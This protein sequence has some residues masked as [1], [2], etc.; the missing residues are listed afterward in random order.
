MRR[1]EVTLAAVVGLIVTPGLAL[2]LGACFQSA[3]PSVRTAE[4]AASQPPV[5]AAPADGSSRRAP[6]SEPPPS[7][8]PPRAEEPPLPGPSPR[9][10]PSAFTTEPLDGSSATRAA[11]ADATSDP[12]LLR[13]GLAT[14][15]EEAVIPCCGR[16]LVLTSGGRRWAVRSPLRVLPDAGST[17]RGAFRLQ[18]AALKDEG[19]ARDL[20]ARLAA[21]SGFASDFHF[22]AGVD[23][24]RVRL[25]R[26][27]SRSE[28]ETARGR[29]EVLG[30]TGAWIV[31]EGGEISDPAFLVVRAGQGADAPDAVRL[32]GRWLSLT[33]AGE[34]M[35]D[36]GAAVPGLAPGIG[37]YRGRWLLYLNDRGKLNLINEVDLEDYLRSVV[38]SEMGPELYGQPEALKAQAVA[39]RTYTLRNLGE[40]HDEG[41]D[42][43]ATPRC[44]VYRGISS[45]HPLSDRA[46]AET[47][48]QV[49]IH[50]G[51]L[52]DA[53]YSATC[54]GHTEDVQVVF[55]LED[56][57][58]LRGV[59]CPE[60][61]G[62]HLPGGL[63]PGEVF[64]YGLLDRHLP[65]D[66]G[67]RRSDLEQRLRDLAR[68]T[69]LPA[70]HDRLRSLRREE[71][72]RFVASLFDLVLDPRMLA[73]AREV[74][75][76]VEDPPVGW[77]GRELARASE[78]LASGLLD[79]GPE[80]LSPREAELLPLSLGRATGHLVE[81]VA[82]HLDLSD[83]G[84]RV[85]RQNGSHEVLPVAKNL[86]TFQRR[87]EVAVATDLQLVPGD[88]LRLIRWRSGPGRPEE[89]L[90][91]IHEV[92]PA[93]AAFRLR[94]PY[95][96]WRRF[97]SD[98][99]L[100]RRVATRYPGFDFRGLE[101][102]SRGVSGRVGEMRLRG[103]DGQ[104]VEVTGLA[105]RWTL[106]LPDTR[107]TARRTT[108]RDG[109]RGWLFAGSGWGHGVGLCQVGAVN[110]AGRGAGYRQIL[111]HFYT[112]VGLAR[113]RRVP[114][115]WTDPG[116]EVA[117]PTV[118]TRR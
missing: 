73:S 108:A 92:E 71:V 43:C 13:V 68:R 81:D 117:T 22:D 89:L 8:S 17:H 79:P 115:R 113:V 26:F 23:L 46:V 25:G 111:E 118:R 38:P 7:T 86:A 21:R 37:H 93:R 102:L 101:V 47:R 94:S 9:P 106:D 60:T 78:L 34:A 110:L 57:P 10:A 54:G 41:Y 45:E 62:Q 19:Q 64:P 27:A 30:V 20:A 51:R 65:A 69:G 18:V 74:R 91:V 85:R 14:D 2:S 15:L 55:P 103:S 112:G 32:P 28:A 76:L 99:E 97:K 105:V 35:M 36:D 109:R 72:R 33:A 5:S 66:G 1:R 42:I 98:A 77:S 59:P 6:A 39:A 11:G 95:A 52:A 107:F 29:L 84:W 100:E 50:E 3:A 48:G 61:G 16:E 67:D 82:F 40:F 58:Y 96:S 31:G 70:S 75:A 63:P 80:L 87:G 53:R 44:Q 114:E 116:P 4:D 104:K 83:D 88:R 24:Y 56:A 90:A 49:V 12:V